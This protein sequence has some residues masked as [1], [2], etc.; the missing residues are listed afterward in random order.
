MR[1]VLSRCRRPENADIRAITKC[2]HARPESVHQIMRRRYGLDDEAHVRRRYQ[3]QETLGLTLPLPKEGVSVRRDDEHRTRTETCRRA[4]MKGRPSDAQCHKG[5]AK[6]DLVGKQND[7]AGD[8]RHRRRTGA[9]ERRRSCAPDALRPLSTESRIAVPKRGAKR[10]PQVESF[11]PLNH[12]CSAVQHRGRHGQL[13]CGPS[14]QARR[15]R[16]QVPKKPR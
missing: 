7:L 1:A 15:L 4:L 12:G 11:G 10:S 16:P 13:R 14:V 3:L 6:P 5:L 8:V 9:G 2:R